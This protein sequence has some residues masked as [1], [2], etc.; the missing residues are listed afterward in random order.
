MATPVSYAKATRPLFRQVDIDH[1]KPF[2]VKLNDYGWMSD[3]DVAHLLGNTGVF[4]AAVDDFVESRL[5]ALGQA[6]R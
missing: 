4:R 6:E 1:M 5:V 3:P 2:D